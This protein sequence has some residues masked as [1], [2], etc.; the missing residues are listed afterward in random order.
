[1]INYT[2][3]CYESTMVSELVIADRRLTGSSIGVIGA[4][5]DYGKGVLKW[6]M[7]HVE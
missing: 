7:I 6:K 5:G 3:R 1:M 4:A 2:Y